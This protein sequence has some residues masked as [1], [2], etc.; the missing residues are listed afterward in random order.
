VALKNI[1]ITHHRRKLAVGAR[2]QLA[3]GGSWRAIAVGARLH[4]VPGILSFETNNY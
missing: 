1:L 3:R 4:R 2:W